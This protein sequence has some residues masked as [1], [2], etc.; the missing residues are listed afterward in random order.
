MTGAFQMIALA[1]GGASAAAMLSSWF[2]TWR[3]LRPP[4]YRM[5]LAALGAPFARGAR[6]LT[7]PTRSLAKPDQLLWRSGPILAAGSVLLAY[8]VIPLGPGIVPIDLGLGLFYFIVILGPLM[9]GFMNAGWGVNGKFDV[10]ATVR[11]AAH[12]VA[13]E[14]T[15]GFAVLGAPMMAQTLSTV[16]IV[17]AQQRVWFVVLQ[18][19]SF[20]IYVVS[21]LFIAYR[22]PFDLPFGGPE[23]AG[24]VGREYGGVERAI[25]VGARHSLLAAT[26]AIGVVVFLGGW[27][28]PVVP[29]P[30]WFIL[31][32]ALLMGAFTAL[33]LV[34]PRLRL[35]Q[36]LTVAW[37][38]LLPL[39]L[40][41]IVVVGLTTFPAAALGWIP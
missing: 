24:G 5:G 19:G 25:F 10:V 27:L 22:H 41:N 4:P 14:V 32:A 15:F 34:L 16:G 11:A 39:S 21:A 6:L 38:G 31:K 20:A 33:P 3:G 30:L 23:I 29:A 40:A 18:P 7:S 35:D 1:L 8:A 17:E 36:M 13:Y 12:I 28:G 9:V 2:A 37:K 26:A